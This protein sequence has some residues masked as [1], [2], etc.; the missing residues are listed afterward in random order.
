MPDRIGG[1]LP[2]ELPKG[3]VER[4]PTL[5]HLEGAIGYHSGR[6]AM[7][8]LVRASGASEV[9]LPAWTCPVVWETLAEAGI[10]VIRYRV[11]KTLQPD[12]IQILS[13]ACRNAVVIL[14]SYFGVFGPAREMIAELRRATGTRVLLDLAQSLYETC[15]DTCA[16]FYS[17]RKFVGIPDG[18]LLVVGG[19]SGFETPPPPSETVDQDFFARR[20]SC[21][22]L[23]GEY[24]SREAWDLYRDTEAE[25]QAGPVAMSTLSGR[26]LRSLDHGLMAARRKANCEALCRTFGIASECFGRS[27][28]LCFPLLL[29]HPVEGLREKLVE[30]GI[31]VPHYWPGVPP[32]ADLGVGIL[33]L[34]LD[35]RYLPADMEEMGRRV[36]AL[37]DESGVS[38]AVERYGG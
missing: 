14:N 4:Q 35:Q 31:L 28:P 33:A 32:E 23:R 24:A 11:L 2:L 21:L 27:I 1:F 13:H 5:S 38:V 10:P 37:L 30:V 26:L 6:S 12:W 18:G 34:P 29:D 16:A 19:E 36:S 17:P 25:M 7:I 9:I 22:G 15:P 8:E 3:V 20:L